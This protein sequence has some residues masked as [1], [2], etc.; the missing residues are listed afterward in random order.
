MNVAEFRAPDLL[1]GAAR[2]NISHRFALTSLRLLLR[3]RLLR[4]RFVFRPLLRG[5]G[6]VV[7]L[8]ADVN[9]IAGVGDEVVSLESLGLG[10]TDDVVRV[11]HSLVAADAA[12]SP[13]ADHEERGTG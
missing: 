3:L 12:R 6:Q 13:D 7:A 4:L 5:W 9:H 1:Q 2:A 8:A 11:E 10:L